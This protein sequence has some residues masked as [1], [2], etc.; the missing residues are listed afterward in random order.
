MHNSV[1]EAILNAMWELGYATLRFNFRGVGRSEGTHDGGPGETEDAVEAVR[2]ITRL[3]GMSRDGVVLAGYSFGAM[4]AAQAAVGMP[5]VFTVAAVAPPVLEEG[6]SYLGRAKKRLIIVAGE[7]DLYC[8]LSELE[9]LRASLLCPLRIK[10]LA[11]TD[12]F[13]VGCEAEVTAALVDGL[14]GA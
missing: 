14:S 1:V 6:A 2:F 13:F 11:G 9:V 3:P 12:H 10:A 8:P 5:E 4:V 7:H